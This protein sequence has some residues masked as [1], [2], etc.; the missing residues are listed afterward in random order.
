MQL[1]IRPYRQTDLA[2]LYEICLLTADG[3]KDASGLFDDKQLVGHFY[4]APYGV[5]EADACIVV[6]LDGKVSGYV[7]GAKDSAAF[8]CTLELQWFPDLRKAFPL[9]VEDATTLPQK[10]IKHIH[11]GYQ[12][13]PE[14]SQY[15]AHLHINLLPN[16]QGLGVG[17]K[18][19]QAFIDNLKQLNVSGLHLEV[20]SDNQTAI[21]FYKKLGFQQIAEFEHSLGFGLEL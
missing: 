14:F 3:G 2:A 9:E 13:R 8:A 16:L 5:F 17:K 21:G 1:E 4:S 19:M 11:N 12:P 20:S 7:V 6:T 15:P 18:I 10:V